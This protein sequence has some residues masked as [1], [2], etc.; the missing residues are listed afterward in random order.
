MKIFTRRKQKPFINTVM[1][2]AQKAY[3]A[4]EGT[5]ASCI[6]LAFMTEQT[7]TPAVIPPKKEIQKRFQAGDGTIGLTNRHGVVGAA[8]FMSKRLRVLAARGR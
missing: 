1:K 8:I 7:N 4:K 3:K 2:K 6:M 5:L